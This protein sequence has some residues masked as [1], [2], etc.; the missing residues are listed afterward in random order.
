MSPTSLA[1]ALPRSTLF[2]VYWV[3]QG[4]SCR[5]YWY[6]R[7]LRVLE[8]A[9][10]HGSR[11]I[12]APWVTCS[13][14][15]CCRRLLTRRFAANLKTETA[16]LVPLR[17]AFMRARSRLSCRTSPLTVNTTDV[18]VHAC[19]LSVLDTRRCLQMPRR[20]VLRLTPRRAG[21]PGPRGSV[22]PRLTSLSAACGLQFRLRYV[23]GEFLV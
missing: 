14:V 20:S 13:A 10:C 3:H 7:M 21:P 5:A 6:R 19:S 16:L 2:E 22:K 15:Y 23:I 12:V 1:R 17:P 18:V 8:L 11:C 9:C 4:Y